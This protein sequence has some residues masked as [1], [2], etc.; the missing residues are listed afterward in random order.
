MYP[1]RLAGAIVVACAAA[2]CAVGPDYRSPAPAAPPRFQAAL[3]AAQA[4]LVPADSEPASAAPATAAAAA[5]LGLA[6]WR[7][8]DDPLLVV[9]VQAAQADAPGLAQALARLAQ[10]RAL[11]QGAGAARLPELGVGIN[12]TRARSMSAPGS[13]L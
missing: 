6:W 13:S 10:A 4:G 11:Y 12:A 9:L 2:G 8:F 3:P 1:T 7:Q 5:T